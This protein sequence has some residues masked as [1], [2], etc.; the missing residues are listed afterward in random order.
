MKYTCR[1]TKSTDNGRTFYD[2]EF[3]DIPEAFS[4]ADTLE[5]ARSSAKDVLDSILTAKLEQGDPLPVARTKADPKKGLEPVPV[6]DRLAIAY[7]IFEA[8]RGKSAAEVARKMGISRQAYQRLEDPKA[9][10]TV[11]TLV[12]AAKALGKQLDIAFV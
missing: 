3:P 2:V 10:L 7:T 12:K 4:C 11:A 8:R 1:I 9:S 5:E 6:D